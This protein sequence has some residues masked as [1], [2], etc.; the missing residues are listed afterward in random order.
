M[1]AGAGFLLVPVLTVSVAVPLAG[2]FRATDFVT[3]QLPFGGAPEQESE[4]E[5]VKPLIGVRVSVYVAVV[6]GFTVCV[7]GAAEI[8]KSSTR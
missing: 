8:E 6:P 1:P 5:P 3:E 7:E 4:T 2:P